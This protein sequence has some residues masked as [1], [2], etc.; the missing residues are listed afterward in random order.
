MA[1]LELARGLDQEGKFTGKFPLPSV[2]KRT[3][4]VKWEGW[5]C[6]HYVG[7]LEMETT[8]C[9]ALFEAIFDMNNADSIMKLTAEVWKKR[10]GCK[11]ITACCIP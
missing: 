9:K 10:V 3:S 4:S 7:N 11:I 2:M 8:P 6:N 1:R 5:G